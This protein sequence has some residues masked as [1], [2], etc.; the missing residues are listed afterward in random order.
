M[1]T[2]ITA[3][4]FNFVRLTP[5]LRLYLLNNFLFYFENVKPYMHKEATQ[6]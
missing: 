2:N 3:L 4:F 1:S 5:T 6:K